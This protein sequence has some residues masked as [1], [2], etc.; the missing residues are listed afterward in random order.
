MG[1]F[2]P[3]LAAAL[4]AI[5]GVFL[6]SALGKN[7]FEAFGAFF[8]TP[9]SNLDGLAELLLKASPLVL[10]ALGL[11]VGFRANVWN[12]GAEGQLILG[13]IAAGGVALAYPESNRAWLQ[14]GRAHV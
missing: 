12:I 11:A 14:I 13:A 7:P 4:T 3:L 6:F 10:C 9:V 5:V 8:V 2:S 1:Y